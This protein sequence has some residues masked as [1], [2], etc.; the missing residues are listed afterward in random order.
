MTQE[1]NRKNEKI[2]DLVDDVIAE[3]NPFQYLGT[4]DIWIDDDIFDN[5]DI[6]NVS[7][8]ILKGIKEND[9]YLD[10]NISTK[11][12]IGDLFELSDIEKVTI[13]DS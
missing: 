9:P 12:V 13:K 5:Q 6:V 7:K 11:T 3:D 2:T 1:L 4:E 8:D 10:F